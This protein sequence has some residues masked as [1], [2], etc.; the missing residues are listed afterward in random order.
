M[1]STALESVEVAF[2][3]CG[4]EEDLSLFSLSVTLLLFPSGSST[5][6]LLQKLL[7]LFYHIMVMRESLHIF[8]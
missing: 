1:A 7:G 3:F 6:V 5:F 8:K 4:S 2:N